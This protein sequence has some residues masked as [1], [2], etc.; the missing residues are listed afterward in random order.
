M[1]TLLRKAAGTW[2]SKV[3]LVLLVLSFAVWGISGQIFGGLGSNVMVVGDTRVSILEYRLAYDRQVRLLSQQFG[4]QLTREQAQAFGVDNQVLAQLLAGAV[5]DEQA[6]EMRLGL[7]RDRLAVLTSQDPAFHGPDGRFDRVQFDWVL[8]QVGMRPQDY[9]RNREQVAIREQIVEAVSD[10]LDAPQTLVEALA[11]YQGEDRTVEYVVL[12]RALVEPVEPP[13]EEAVAAFFEENR[14]NYAAPEFRTISYVKLEPQ[15]IADPASVTDEEAR[16]EYDRARARYTTPERRTIQQLVFAD[17]EAAQ[18]AL[19]RVR[20]GATFEEIA[21]EQGRAIGD[22][23]LGTFSRD[24]VADPAIAEAAFALE[25]GAVS[26]VV[27]GAFGPILVRVTAVT[28]EVARPFEE[29]EAEIRSDLALDE[30]GRILTEVH[31][32]YEDARAGGETMEEA[33]SRQRLAV[34]RIEAV[35]RGGRTPEGTILTDIPESAALLREAF[36]TEIGIENPPLNLGSVGFLFYE[37][38]A[39]TPA[40]ERTLDEVR[41]RVVADWTDSE[42]QS[43][44]AQ[45]AV[46]IERRLA[47]GGDLAAIAEEIEA[48]VQIRR[49]LTRDGSD[50][51]LGDDGVVAAFSVARGE[52]AL[53]RG[54]QADTQIVLRVTDVSQPLAGGADSVPQEVREGLASGIA[55]DLVDQLVARLQGQYSVQIDRNAI[56]QALSF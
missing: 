28:P 22:T 2:V 40:R 5:L 26:D 53:V 3:L 8:R 41:E 21:A 48:E 49:G 20:D 27:P 31:D 10:G 32:A 55:D 11:L 50:A 16:A 17:E 19:T 36:E 9:L 18:A 46:E 39:I 6:R 45:R 30:A 1:L 34:T 56:Q 54:P 12:P 4:T 29:V 43:R 35:D 7:S 25:E 14:A 47:D 33:A 23:E 24:Q 15:D 13:S 52:T 51:G 37:V 42:A 38:D 44:L